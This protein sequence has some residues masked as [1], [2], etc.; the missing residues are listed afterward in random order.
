ML[1]KFP[2]FLLVLLLLSGCVTGYAPV[3][4]YPDLSQSELMPYDVAMKVIKS[5]YPSAS[6][7]GMNFFPTYKMC[8]PK[9]HG[10]FG[11]IKTVVLDQDPQGGVVVRLISLQREGPCFYTNPAYP[12]GFNQGSWDAYAA[13]SLTE[14]DANLVLNALAAVGASFRTFTLRYDNNFTVGP[15]RSRF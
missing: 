2:P 1:S 13:A 14:S 7:T 3:V 15:P 8:A 6:P 9:W 4:Y 5:V 12:N 11:T 10:D